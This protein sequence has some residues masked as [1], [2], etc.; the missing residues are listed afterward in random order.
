[1]NEEME[2]I[3]YSKLMIEEQVNSGK[4]FN[5]GMPFTKYQKVYLSTNENIKD[6]LN[7]KK[8]NNKDSALSVLASG[9]QVF[10][11][12][13][14]DINNIDTFDT[15]YLTQ[16]LVF[17]LKYAM[18]QKYSYKGYLKTMGKFININ[19]NI[20]EITSIINDLLPYMDNKYKKYWREII[21]YNYSLQRNNS[22][23]INLF[24]MLYININS[25]I[26]FNEE[27][28]NILKE[29][30]LKTNIA[31]DNI[32]S[33]DLNKLDNKYDL[34]LLSNILDYFSN[35]YRNNNKRFNISEL[36]KY[37]ES[38]NQLLKEDGIIFLNY[39]F[40]YAS[41]SFEKKHIFKNSEIKSSELTNQE[42]YRIKSL[43]NN[44]YDG[45]ILS[46]KY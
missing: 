29:R 9:D 42:I 28:Y 32:N 15:N 31:F 19:T 16:Y 18:I 39:I 35:I 7:L 1:M 3:E 24:H 34:I 45:V 12:I 27:E 30:L 40:D 17:G 23:Y 37:I 22:S 33:V 25:N 38:I 14:K 46:K 5:S 11:L 13:I 41:D 26:L 4:C 8:Y 43:N 6:Y 44:C 2:A 20:E 36:N 10:N 21:N